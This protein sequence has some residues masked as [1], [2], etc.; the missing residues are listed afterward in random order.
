MTSGPLYDQAKE[1]L[2]AAHRACLTHPGRDILGMSHVP[3]SG[4]NVALGIISQLENQ[5]RRLKALHAKQMAACNQT[6]MPV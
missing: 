1:A 3:F 6:L 2:E 5:N 4:V